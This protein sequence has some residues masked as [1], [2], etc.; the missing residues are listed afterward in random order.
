MIDS[1]S[2]TPSSDSSSGLPPGRVLVVDDEQWLAVGLARI[3]ERH[4][5]SA[6]IAGNGLEA[7]AVLQQGDIVAVISDIDM[8][9]L[10]GTQ[11]I[12]AIHAQDPTL[13]VMFITGVPDAESAAAAV[14]LGAYKYLT[15][16]FDP[17]E[18]VQATRRAIKMRNVA[19]ARWEMHEQTPQQEWGAASPSITKLPTFDDLDDALRQ[20]FLV[21][22]PIIAVQPGLPLFGYEVLLRSANPNWPR[23]DKLISAARAGGRLLQLERRI[24][25]LAAGP[26][27]PPGVPQFVNLHPS[28]LA[29]PELTDPGSPL[30]AI[31]S[32]VVLEITEA[33]QLESHTSLR[34][35]LQTLRALGYRIALDDLGSGFASL[36]NLFAIEPDIVKLDMALVRNS[37]QDPHKRRLVE[38]IVRACRQMGVS[39]V[40]EGIETHA[41]LTTMIEIGCNLLQG[42]AIARPTRE[43]TVPRVEVDISAFEH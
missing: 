22:Q 33:A 23:P 32:S 6:V 27:R 20:I 16:P 19:V 10:N 36:N 11:L 30:S 24:R 8:P 35:T 31:A 41:E 37:D 38:S 15:K 18:V 34:A 17:D 42:Y 39:V 3:L 9:E 21:Y 26:D 7:L 5:I 29:D 4:G 13:P 40:A 2:R 43:L 14:E 1:N 28:S 25:A 12:R